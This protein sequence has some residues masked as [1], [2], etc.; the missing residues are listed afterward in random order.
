MCSRTSPDR[1]ELMV[2]A[3]FS[4]WANNR[5]TWALCHNPSRA[6]LWLTAISNRHW[7]TPS[8]RKKLFNPFCHFNQDTMGF[9]PWKTEGIVNTRHYC[10]ESRVRSLPSNSVVFKKTKSCWNTQIDK[11]TY[12]IGLWS[13]C[14]RTNL[15]SYL[16]SRKYLGNYQN[17]SD[18]LRCL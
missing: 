1:H 14:L 13:E 7:I 16:W 17:P 5:R 11:R 6:A 8:L 18:P 2:Q 3:A 12:L 4:L 9:S 10:K 15:H